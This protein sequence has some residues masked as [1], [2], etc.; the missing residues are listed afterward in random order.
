MGVTFDLTDKGT[1]RSQVYC[2]ITD[3]MGPKKDNG[4]ADDVVGRWYA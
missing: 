2:H 1:T 4:L 3:V